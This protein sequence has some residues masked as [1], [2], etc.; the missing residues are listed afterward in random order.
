MNMKKIGVAIL[1]VAMILV[2]GSSKAYAVGSNKQV[3]QTDL[4]KFKVSGVTPKYYT[5]K[6]ITINLSVTDANNKKLVKDT[7]YTVT[8]ANNKNEGIATATIKGKGNYKGTITKKFRIIQNANI[9]TKKEYYITSQ[10]INGRAIDCGKDNGANIVTST[11]NCFDPQKFKF[12]KNSDGTYYIQNP[13][14]KDYIEVAGGK[15]GTAQI[16]LHLSSKQNS[17]AQKFFIGKN[18][19]GTITFYTNNGLAFEMSSEKNNMS[20]WIN[21]ANSKDTQQFKLRKTDDYMAV[22]FDTSFD[23]CVVLQNNQKKALD[24]YG[25][26]TANGTNVDLY[27]LN[28]SDAQIFRF[29]RNSDGTFTIINK[30]SKKALDVYGNNTNNGANVDIYTSNKST[31]QKWY[32]IRNKDYSLT[33]L[34]AE[35]GRVLDA[36]G[37]S[38]KNLTN[39][40]LWNWNGRDSQK[41][42]F[43]VLGLDK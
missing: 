26:K 30:K 28:K 12:I 13:K 9:D 3:K 43:V 15:T 39:I 33:F 38:T 23:I 34:G 25:G 2:L 40:Q 5:G 8:Y 19:N 41:W 36:K 6:N 21:N 7:D 1:L 42:N 17:Y 14:T 24:V 16:G 22:N 18:S 32:I 10:L 35:S 27:D 29:T 37:G 31:A 11:L 4:S 20:L